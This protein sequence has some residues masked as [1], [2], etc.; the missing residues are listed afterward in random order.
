MVALGGVRMTEQHIVVVDD[1]PQIR[2]MLQR[3]LEQEGFRVS[4]AEGGEEMWRALG[5]GADLVILDLVLPGEDGFTLAREL[6]ARTDIPF[7]LVTGKGDVVD[8]V[9]GL[10]AGAD[11]YITK[12]FHLREVLARVRLVLRRA[13]GREDQQPDSDSADRLAFDGWQL[14]LGA[15]EL[16]SPAGERVVLT[17]G[18]FNLLAALARNQNRPMSRDQ[19]MDALRGRE[20]T[21]YDRSI[22]TQVGRLRRKLEDDASDPKLIKTVRGV[23]YVLSTHTDRQR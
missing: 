8:R 13:H 15:R 3:Y 14:D 1:D 23:G 16:F 20:W 10:E 2:R 21:A 11:D 7:M 12:P 5:D 4:A 19:L 9:A 22:D 17:T 6:Q 18:E